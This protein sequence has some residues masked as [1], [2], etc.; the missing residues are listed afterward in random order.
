MGEEPETLF[1]GKD[2]PYKVIEG[3]LCKVIGFTPFA[4]I[5][6]GEVKAATKVMPYALLSLES[7]VL[8]KGKEY[9]LRIAHRIDFSHLW[10]AFKVRGIDN[11]KEEVLIAYVSSYRN[12]WLKLFSSVHPK[13][14]VYIFP[15][16]HLEQCYDRNFKPDN[17]NTWWGPI[18]EW[19]PPEDWH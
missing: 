3:Q 1:I 8:P 7:P 16:G 17:P 13:L 5:L 4:V 6:D 14:H 12:I 19:G 9:I 2:V 15:I 11:K 18:A 10:E